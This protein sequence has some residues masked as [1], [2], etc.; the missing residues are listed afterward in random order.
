MRRWT[1]GEEIAE[2]YRRAK[3]LIDTQGVVARGYP[4]GSS[5]QKDFRHGELT[6]CLTGEGLLLVNDT[7]A[8]VMAAD[9]ETGAIREVFGSTAYNVLL[10]MR[11]MM[12][13]D[14]V[15]NA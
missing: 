12:V 11:E 9:Y 10:K 2:I 15:A 14:D 7:V 1:T 6:I 4:A 5:I 8:G 3:Y 13:L